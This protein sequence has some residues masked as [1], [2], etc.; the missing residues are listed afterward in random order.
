[1]INRVVLVG[2]LTKDP[3]DLRRSANDTAFLSFTLAV[4]N[5][6]KNEEKSAD[7]IPCVAFNK[8]AEIINQYTHKGS[9]IAV[10]GRIQ[11]R[12]YDSK[13][14][15][16]KKVYV[17][18]VICENVQ[19]LDPKQSTGTS[20]NPY[21]TQQQSRGGYENQYRKEVPTSPAKVQQEEAYESQTPPPGI[22]VSDD[23]LPF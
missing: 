9:Q 17:V 15:P 12:S 16:G 13:D 6:S 2:R 3:S 1:M 11:T 22:D 4:D 23:D 8:T 10:E 7:F 14:N 21:P 19:L 5:R 20:P 18:E